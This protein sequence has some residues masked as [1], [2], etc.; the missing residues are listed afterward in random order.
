[1]SQL[2]RSL[3]PL[4]KIRTVERVVLGVIGT[5]STTSDICDLIL[6]PIMEAWSPDEIILPAEGETSFAIQTWADSMQIPV[7]RISCDWTKHGRC[8]KALRDS[9]IQRHSTHLLFLQGPRSNAL[10]T[11]ALR[12]QRKG[13]PV[14]ISERPGLP[15]RCRKDI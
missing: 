4:L 1:M 11:M 6:P 13:R 12:L 14:A 3:S 15:A 7:R 2:A 10:S 9:E 8:A 5:R